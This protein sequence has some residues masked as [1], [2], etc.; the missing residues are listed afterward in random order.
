M[1]TIK[2]NLLGFEFQI[3]YEQMKMRV[4]NALEK[5]KVEDELIN[6]DEERMGFDKWT[7]SFTPRNHPPII[8]VTLPFPFTVHES[9]SIR[10][11]AC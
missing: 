9:C 10:C 8:Q 1:I 2:Y 5:G 6:G 7:K 4:E 11:I 3:M